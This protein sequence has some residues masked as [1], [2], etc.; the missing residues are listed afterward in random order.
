MKLLSVKHLLIL[1]LASIV[2]SFVAI[3]ISG[4][5]WSANPVENVYLF[6][7]FAGII[8]GLLGASAI[9][10]LVSSGIFWLISR[11]PMQPAFTIS[12]YLAWVFGAIGVFLT[13]LP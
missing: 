2:V 13:D 3:G 1:E 8:I 7:L 5:H 9:F 10:A 6:G 12:M 4:K 11:K